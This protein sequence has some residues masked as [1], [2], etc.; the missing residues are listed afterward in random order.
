MTNY[1][2]TVLYIGVTNDLKRRVT[3]H[4]I[5][6]NPLSFTTRYKCYYLVWYECFWD[7]QQAIDREKQLKNWK[8]VWK[9]ALIN[10]E[11]DTWEDLSKEWEEDCGSSPQ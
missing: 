9:D 1:Q 11:N 6:F 4:K 5:G 2:K 10:K 3:E 8:R 7:I